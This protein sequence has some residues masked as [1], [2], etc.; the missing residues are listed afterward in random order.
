M[1]IRKCPDGGLIVSG[2]H[3]VPADVRVG[4]SGSF[5]PIGCSHLVNVETGAR[6]KTVDGYST[7]PRTEVSPQALYDSDD[8]GTVAGMLHRPGG[9][10]RV[11]TCGEHLLATRVPRTLENERDEW[12]RPPPWRCGGHPDV[13]LPTDY[14]GLSLDE[15]T[16]W[17]TLLEEVLRGDRAVSGDC[18]PLADL[19]LW[20]AGVYRAAPTARSGIAIGTAHLLD[21]ADLALVAHAVGFY[22]RSPMVDGAE[23]LAPLATRLLV[24]AS[25]KVGSDSR[26][27]GFLTGALARRLQMTDS[28]GHLLDPSAVEAAKALC[29]SVKGVGVLLHALAAVAPEFLWTHAGQLVRADIEALGTIFRLLVKAPIDADIVLL[30]RELVAASDCSASDV[31]AAAN[32]LLFDPLR[33]KVVEAMH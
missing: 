18:L 21:H 27:G 26:F 2:T 30:A 19:G 1:T 17:S 28:T 12:F 25:P 9:G 20:I 33:S 29:L 11:Y 24:G 15:K 5:K 32:D 23:K 31:I 13:E 8:W 14:D 4:P 7:A 3:F 16:D 10:E 22:R 6:V